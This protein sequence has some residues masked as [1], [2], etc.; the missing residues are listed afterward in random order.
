MAAEQKAIQPV[1][2]RMC[3]GE[4]IMCGL[5]LAMMPKRHECKQAGKCIFA[6]KEAPTDGVQASGELAGLPA[7]IDR[8]AGVDVPEGGKRN[9]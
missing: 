1:R 3:W 4:R 8:A 7:E 2:G 5:Q 9:E 6:P